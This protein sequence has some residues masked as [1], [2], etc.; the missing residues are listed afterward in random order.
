M[1]QETY[2]LP[3]RCKGCNTMFDLWPV[4]QEQEQA[5]GVFLSENHFSRLLKQSFC[6]DCKQAVLLGTAEQEENYLEDNIETPE[7]IDFNESGEATIEAEIDLLL[8]LD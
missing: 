5:S 3:V 7:N 2:M 4:L 8:D 1:K 6:P